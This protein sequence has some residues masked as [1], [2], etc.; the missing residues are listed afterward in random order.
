[1]SFIQEVLIYG[2]E[3]VQH[4]LDAVNGC[5]VTYQQAIWVFGL[6][7]TDNKKNQEMIET[8]FNEN[9]K[10]KNIPPVQSVI[11]FICQDNFRDETY[12][13][14]SNFGFWDSLAARKKEMREYYTHNVCESNTGSQFHEFHTKFYQ[15]SLQLKRL[16][17]VIQPEFHVIKNVHPVSKIPYLSVRGFWLDDNDKKVKLFTKS[18]GR[19]DSYVDGKNDSEMLR[20]AAKQIQEM[21][22]A[23]YQELYS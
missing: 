13:I 3:I 8:F 4:A 11:E 21:S 1:M 14:D 23:K 18:M 9:P 7:I 22:F 20:E 12:K 10:L 6:G 5:G 17:L 16:R 19:E 2:N 15:M